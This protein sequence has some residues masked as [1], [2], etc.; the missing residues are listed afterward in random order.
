MSARGGVIGVTIG[1]DRRRGRVI[2]A[3][4]VSLSEILAEAGAASMPRGT[5]QPGA[6]SAGNF[7]AQ[8]DRLRA[9]KAV[10]QVVCHARG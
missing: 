5:A 2:S 4:P 7:A 10:A 8:G 1:E 3:A 6:I 9:G